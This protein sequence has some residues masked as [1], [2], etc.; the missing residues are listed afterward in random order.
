MMISKNSKVHPRSKA[1]HMLLIPVS[2]CRSWARH[3]KPY[4]YYALLGAHQDLPATVV[5]LTDI[6]TTHYTSNCIF[7]WQK[8]PVLAPMMTFQNK[9]N[10]CGTSAS[11]CL[12]VCFTDN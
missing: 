8:E 6:T 12:L 7:P 10:Y 11:I 3:I 5:A 4:D 1:C 9:W 2:K